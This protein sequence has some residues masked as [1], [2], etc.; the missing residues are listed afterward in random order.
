VLGI[1][2]STLAKREKALIEKRQQQ[3]TSKRGI[4]WALAKCKKGYS[5]INEATRTLLDAAFNDHPHVIVSPNAKDTLQLK[6]TD[7]EKVVVSKVLTQVGLGTIYSNIIK[8]NPTIKI[9]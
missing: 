1:P 7:G 8:D 5:K 9:R 2:Q 3:S 4:L 6:K